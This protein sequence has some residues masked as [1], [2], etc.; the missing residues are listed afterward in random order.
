MRTFFVLLTA[1][2]GLLVTSPVPVNGG[3]AAQGDPVYPATEYDKR[4][5]RIPNSVTVL[6][7]VKRPETNYGTVTNV[8]KTKRNE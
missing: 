8:E 4:Q 7:L 6:R 1:A 3:L 5:R 2:L